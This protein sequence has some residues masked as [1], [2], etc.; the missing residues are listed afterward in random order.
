[1]NN[2]FTIQ[3]IMPTNNTFKV[4]DIKK[5]IIDT[6]DK[7][8]EK[9]EEQKS[10]RYKFFTMDISELTERNNI[11]S[12]LVILYK[13]ALAIEQELHRLIGMYII[14]YKDLI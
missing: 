4:E 7:Y 5:V 9:I 11:K 6:L 1:M 3:P 2:I 12:R 13:E 10:L 8:Y 14:N